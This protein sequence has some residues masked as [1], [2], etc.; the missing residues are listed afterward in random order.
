MPARL[1]DMQF[2]YTARLREHGRYRAGARSNNPAFLAG[3]ERIYH[4][5]RKA[6]VAE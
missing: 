4:G 3:R 2:Q 1:F 6:G 5:M